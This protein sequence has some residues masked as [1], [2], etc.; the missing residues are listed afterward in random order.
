[1]VSERR[2]DFTWVNRWL[3][4]FDEVRSA[5]DTDPRSIVCAGLVLTPTFPGIVW[6]N[7]RAAMEPLTGLERTVWHECAHLA[8]Y[9]SEDEA[10]RVA[11]RH[12]DGSETPCRDRSDEIQWTASRAPLSANYWELSN[13]IRH[14]KARRLPF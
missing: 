5:Y 6:L 9:L 11:D 10:D 1:L 4:W 3:R 14:P 13:Q 7:V 12:V 8:G 2:N